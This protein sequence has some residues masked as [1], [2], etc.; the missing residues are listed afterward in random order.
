MSQAQLMWL[1]V[2]KLAPALWGTHP[3]LEAGQAR[4]G[5]VEALP[6]MRGLQP[7]G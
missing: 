2:W 1:P 6:E 3:E 4:S 5:G 7:C